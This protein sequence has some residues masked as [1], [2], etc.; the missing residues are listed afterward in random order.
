MIYVHITILC[1]YKKKNK[2]VNTTTNKPYLGEQS[3]WEIKNNDGIKT[4]KVNDNASSKEFAYVSYR[5]WFGWHFTK[6][7]LLTN[8]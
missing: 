5:C 6:Q 7:S 3:R 4:R 8:F 2:F 1:I